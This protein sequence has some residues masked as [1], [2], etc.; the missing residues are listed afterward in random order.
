MKGMADAAGISHGAI[1]RINLFPELIR[2]SCSIIGAWGPATANTGLLQVRALDWDDSAPMS[3]Y[4]LVSVYHYTDDEKAQ[5]YANFAWAGVVGSLA[6]FS[7]NVGISEKFRGPDHRNDSS[8]NGEPWMYVLR[9]VL[10]YGTDLESGIGIMWDA[11]KTWKIYVGL[12]A[13][14]DNVFRGI[15]YGHDGLIIFDDKNFTTPNATVHPKM[16]GVVYWDKHDK[17]PSNDPCLGASLEAGYGSLTPEYL[18]RNSTAMLMT[19]DTL[20]AVYDF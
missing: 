19:G 4:P 5:P 16:D 9:D 15:E 8:W 3:K 17:Q 12:G 2:A 1:K 10:Q 20:L 13:T 18:F 11:M 6:G 14:S 7:T